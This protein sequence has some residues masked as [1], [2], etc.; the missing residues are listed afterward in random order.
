MGSPKRVAAGST[1][2]SSSSSRPL[3][4]EC[5]AVCDALAHLHGRPSLKRDQ[6]RIGCEIQEPHS[7]LD[8]LVRTYISLV[9]TH[10]ATQQCMAESTLLHQLRPLRACRLKLVLES[11]PLATCVR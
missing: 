5:V 4:H 7:V 6:P 1:Q 9:A 10:T 11:I 3:P 2:S 8:S